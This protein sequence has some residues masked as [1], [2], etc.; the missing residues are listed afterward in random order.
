MQKA[1]VLMEWMI[2]FGIAGAIIVGSGW[3]L[4]FG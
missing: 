1:L 2:P 3:V 4:V